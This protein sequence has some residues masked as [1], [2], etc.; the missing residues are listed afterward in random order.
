MP[1]L[2]VTVLGPATLHV[3]GHPADLTGRPRD[4]L[5]VL[6]TH[7]GTVVPDADLVEAV[8]GDTAPKTVA[9][10]LQIA[11][12]RI[13]T[14][15]GADAHTLL[16]R[17][18]G[19]YVLDVPTDLA[20]L[21]AHVS[22]GDRLARSG[23]WTAAR[24][25]YAAAVELCGEVPPGLAEEHL[26]ALTRHLVATLATGA[27]DL[28]VPAPGL[29]ER[30][31]HLRVLARAFT[32]RDTAAR[33]HAEAVAT[34]AEEA[35]LDPGREFRA[36][37]EALADGDLAREVDVVRRWITGGSGR[38]VPMELPAAVGDFIGREDELARVTQALENGVVAL[39][40]LGG[41]GK[42][43]LAVRVARTITHDYP[44]GCLFI[45][46]RG[47]DEAPRDPHAVLGSFLRSLGVPDR[48][49][50]A[51]PA[52]RLGLYRT[53]SATR[54]L[55]VVLDN[56][57]DAAQVRDLLPA[58]DG[59]AAIVTAR[60]NLPGLRADHVTIGALPERQAVD[61]LTTVAG[62]DG[63]IGVLR[64]VA[65]LA[66]HLPLALR[67]V[68]A[69]MRRR[70]D[71][72]FGRMLTRL[73]DEHHRLDELAEGDR[74]VR[75]CIEIGYRRLG[76]AA[77]EALRA[78]AWLPV[79][80]FTLVALAGTIGMPVD[81]ARRV[82]DDLI[83]A[84]LMVELG[85][86]RGELARYGLHDLVRLFVLNAD[87]DPDAR[88]ATLVR[89]FRALLTG[90][91]IA[92]ERVRGQ[93]FIPPD[94]PDW[95]EADRPAPD[96]PRGWLSAHHEL[97]VAAVGDA[98]GLGETEL[99]W[100]LTVTSAVSLLAEYRW[101]DFERCDRYLAGLDLPLEARASLLWVRA[102]GARARDEP[103]SALPALRAAR[104]A[105]RRV[106]DRLRAA[107]V[108][109]SLLGGWRE[110]GR[111][112][113]AV[114]AGLS[115][116]ALLSGETTDYREI[117]VRGWLSLGLGNCLAL[118]EPARA[119]GH[120]RSAIDDM[121]AIGNASGE[122]NARAMLGRW[123]GVEGRHDEAVA[124]LRHA[125]DLYERDQS[126]IGVLFTRV[127]LS[128]EHIRADELTDAAELLSAAYPEAERAGVR[129]LTAKIQ[130]GRATVHRRLGEIAEALVLAEESLAI[131]RETT[132][133]EAAL[134][135]LEVLVE[136]AEA[137]GDADRVRRACAEA[138]PLLRDGHPD[139]AFFAGRLK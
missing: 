58:G 74:M 132:N 52:E 77:S 96:D 94:P 136:V 53:L 26:D 19:G 17:E 85:E 133:T 34:L 130:R 61:L 55:L 44:D 9:N 129:A 18:R 13:R 110:T 25:A 82:V 46:L 128:D 91:M 102:M 92:E 104:L 112:R 118:T 5:T 56:A 4:V 98:P 72:D 39:A 71:L 59:C 40:G 33:L 2:R 138:M 99:A 63:D 29:N 22:D 87:P 107:S 126:S 75:S 57:F 62:R 119:A 84:Q 101:D 81:D 93:Q 131:A 125:V 7:A 15:L 21:R 86:G 80:E 134:A 12:H 35:G 51:T 111:H 24:E 31:W 36:L 23:D 67:I 88:R 28:D 108:A 73:T 89:G 65:R 83:D 68:G 38:P 70:R 60:T 41:T 139:H 120:Y 137:A 1:S 30:L 103:A 64:E 117:G 116:L 43:A 27:H 105:Y 54:R 123:H 14:T 121:H 122:A 95:Y 90:M 79:P 37:G 76:T 11:V 127:A 42:T 97:A 135:S 114:A 32:D 16:R 50:P 48:D 113:L 66:G 3:D 100:R 69:R 49:V 106:G 115:G 124:E 10:Q 20:E 8:W 6:A 78:A 45:D 47:V 109:H